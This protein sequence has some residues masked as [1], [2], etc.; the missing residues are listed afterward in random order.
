[1][2]FVCN[3]FL[4]LITLNTPCAKYDP[5]PRLTMTGDEML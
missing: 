4:L 3:T 1:M 5:R 2:G